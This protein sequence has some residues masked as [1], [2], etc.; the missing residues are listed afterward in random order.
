MSTTEDKLHIL[1]TDVRLTC[2][3]FTEKTG[4]GC[5]IQ[6]AQTFS[7]SAE[8]QPAQRGYNNNTV[9]TNTQQVLPD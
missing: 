7:K 6:D 1:P 3:T 2:P 5:P 4:S 8:T 9:Y